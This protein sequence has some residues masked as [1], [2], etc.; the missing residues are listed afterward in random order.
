MTSGERSGRGGIWTVSAEGLRT[1]K[2]RGYHGQGPSQ[3]FFFTSREVVQVKTLILWLW[4]LLVVDVLIGMKAGAII[5]PIHGSMRGR[6]GGN[7][8]SH[9]KGGDYVRLGTAPTNPQTS[10]QQ[11]TRSQLGTFAASW[12]TTLTQAQRDAWDVYA[13]ANPV[14]NSLGEDIL[15]SGLAWYVK[16]NTVLADAGATG[17]SSPPV[18]AAPFALATVSVDISAATTVDVTFTA[19]PLGAG[20]RLI[21]WI[22]LPVSAGS[23]PNKAQ[24][25]L[26]GY[27]AAAAA[28]PQAVTTPHS[29][30]SGERGVVYAGVLSS[31]GLMSAFMQAIDD[32]DY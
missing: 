26:C 5:S 25:R 27:S 18:S 3:L 22:S 24:T 1:W 6:I 20:E 28:S 14:K 23:T 12:T 17:I 15:I 7:V 29:F 16:C 21:T 11:T 19:T 8:Y 30:Q 32:S 2:A 13:A 4:R 9:N 10:R 31:E